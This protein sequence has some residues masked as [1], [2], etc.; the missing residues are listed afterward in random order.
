MPETAD[1]TGLPELQYCQSIKRQSIQFHLFKRLLKQCR[2][3]ARGSVLKLL[4]TVIPITP[5]M[6]APAANSE[7]QWI[8]TEIAN[9]T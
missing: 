5:P 3:A 6:M 7:N 2:R 9:P 8:V 4:P 1:G